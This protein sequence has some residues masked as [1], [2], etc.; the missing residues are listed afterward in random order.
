MPH[1]TQSSHSPY[2]GRISGCQTQVLRLWEGKEGLYCEPRTCLCLGPRTGNSCTLNPLDSKHRGFCLISIQEG[3]LEAA[4]E[5][6]RKRRDPRL[7]CEAKRP[8]DLSA[9]K[10][11]LYVRLCEHASGS[12]LSRGSSGVGSKQTQSGGGGGVSGMGKNVF[13]AS[14]QLRVRNSITTTT[15]CEGC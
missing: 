8:G 12:A 1:H 13:G 10:T 11:L 14:H 3:H 7:K 5:N 6:S 4:I 9:G 2:K 15:C